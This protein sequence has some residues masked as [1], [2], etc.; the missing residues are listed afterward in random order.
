[1]RLPCVYVYKITDGN[2]CSAEAEGLGRQQ[3]SQTGRANQRGGG[4]RVLPIPARGRLCRSYWPPLLPPQVNVAASGF[5]RRFRRSAF[6]H[7]RVR[8]DIPLRALI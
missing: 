4:D 8:R 5:R 1:M 2:D 7:Q 3:V 6:Q